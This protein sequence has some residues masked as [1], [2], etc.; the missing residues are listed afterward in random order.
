[1][2]GCVLTLFLGGCIVGLGHIK[3]FG[4]QLAYERGLVCR[5][6]YEQLQLGGGGG[7]DLASSL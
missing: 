1:M 2:G 6:R 7:R 5:L 4:V 3:G